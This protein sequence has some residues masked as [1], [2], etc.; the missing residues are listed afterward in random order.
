M[1]IIE[2][3]RMSRKKMMRN[4]I[5]GMKRNFFSLI[6]VSNK[7]ILPFSRINGMRRNRKKKLFFINGK[8]N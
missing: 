7:F 3:L 4:K 2:T 6:L 8:N 5:R 1:T